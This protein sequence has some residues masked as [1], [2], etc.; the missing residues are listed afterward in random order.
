MNIPFT[1]SFN[2]ALLGCRGQLLHRAHNSA[3]I[4]ISS[5]FRRRKHSWDINV[6]GAI[7]STAEPIKE[8]L[9]GWVKEHYLRNLSR[10]LGLSLRKTRS[11]D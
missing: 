10:R 9:F 2:I 7:D 6:S 11:Y 3:R 1:G 8:L 5:N 4:L